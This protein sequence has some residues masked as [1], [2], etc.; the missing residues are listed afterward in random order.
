MAY[1]NVV[2][3]P[4]SVASV[5][6]WNEKRDIALT[7][8]PV[9]LR[10]SVPGTVSPA[11]APPTPVEMLTNPGMEAPYS[12]G[13][14][15]G[16]SDN[17]YGGADLTQYEVTTNPHSG[18][19][20]QG[21]SI[22]TIP[23]GSGHYFYQSLSTEPGVVYEVSMWVRSDDSAKIRLYLRNG[24]PDY[25]RICE[26]RHV[27]S[28]TWEQISFRGGYQEGFDNAQ[29]CIAFATP[30]SVVIDDL[31]VKVYADDD[32]IPLTGAIP[33]TL[34]G[35]HINKWGT[36][37]TWPRDKTDH[38]L[39]RMWDT[40][41]EWTSLEAT[42]GNW[43]WARLDLYMDEVT[44]EEVIMT[45]GR[46]PTWASSRGKNYPPDDIN[47]WTNYVTTVATRYQ[48]KIN[49][50]EVWNEVNYAGF[51]EGTM[52]ELVTLT[53]AAATALAAVDPNIKLLSP[54]YTITGMGNLSEFLDLGGATNCD[55]ISYHEYPLAD[56]EHMIGCAEAI[57][58][59]LDHYGVSLPIWNTEGVN[60]DP[61][62]TFSLDK[63][64]GLIV[65]DYATLWAYGVEIFGWYAWDIA[66][67]ERL[68]LSVLN[69]Y[70][71]YSD[72][73]PAYPKGV[74]WL[75]GATY[76]DRATPDNDWHIQMDMPTGY[77]H[78]LWTTDVPAIYTLDA[79]LQVDTE[80]DVDSNSYTFVGPPDI[81]TTT[82]DSVAYDLTPHVDAGG[83]A[84]SNW[85]VVN[86]VPGFS[87]PAD[88]G[89]L[90]MAANTA[91]S[92]YVL[93]I[94]VD[95][96]AGTSIIGYVRWVQYTEP[97]A[98]Q[99]TGPI[100]DTSSDIADP[101]PVDHS[102][103]GLY[104]GFPAPSFSISPAVPGFSINGT[105]VR[106]DGSAV[107]DHAIT[108]VADNGV[109]PNAPNNFTW[110]IT[111]SVPRAPTIN[112]FTSYNGVPVDID[113][114]TGWE[115]TNGG[116]WGLTNPPTGLSIDGGTGR[117]TGTPSANGNYTPVAITYND[118]T[119]YSTNSVTWSIVDVPPAPEGT[120]GG[121]GLNLNL[122]I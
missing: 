95:N 57:R 41:T 48:G 6:T 62:Y 60:K 75:E 101:Q 35:M 121:M 44:T 54:N 83:S 29:L 15:D 117:I 22:T 4:Y 12:G 25:Q 20:A 50:Y 80:E 103:A 63:R 111:D 72:C 84:L 108:V 14:A 89:I 58:S 33:Q 37:S 39:V 68:E 81:I 119:L 85:T 10:S 19:S 52:A 30:G 90:V 105:D 67:N 92:E 79:G 76:L 65:R 93:Q 13:N 94:T 114:T 2:N 47:D 61:G 78:L 122:K 23:D 46:S 26:L 104:T 77:G 116:T 73:G 107:G 49:Y 16:W 27:P 112:N 51:Y 109:L 86:A 99:W 45:L 7:Q 64:K 55:I 120:S 88:D 118:G 32:S 36:Y 53:N 17:A 3:V 115:N 97:A 87:F 9:L 98:P 59:E 102:F 43:N 100:D 38:G 11:P 113:G 42:K 5:P 69:N 18:T 28:A 96:A 70:D 1:S 110:T 24:D 71:T 82:N 106:S 34:F 40:G 56:P 31:S 66:G 21:L 74:E 8:K 91:S